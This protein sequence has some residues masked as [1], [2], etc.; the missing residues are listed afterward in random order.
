MENQ[1]GHQ[2]KSAFG[3]GGSDDESVV[4]T[5]GAGAGDEI[6]SVSNL[7]GVAGG[8]I[9]VSASVGAT[10]PLMRRVGIALPANGE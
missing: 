1:N 5:G 7:R 10:R 2:N 6:R 8:G 9:G 3:S 4:S